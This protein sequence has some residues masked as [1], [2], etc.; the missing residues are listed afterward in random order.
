MPLPKTIDVRIFYSVTGALS[1]CL[2]ILLVIVIAQC[3][4]RCKAPRNNAAQRL[5]GCADENNYGA[6][7]EQRDN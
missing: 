6:V 3:Y 4:H 2:M 5:R 7:D 1:L